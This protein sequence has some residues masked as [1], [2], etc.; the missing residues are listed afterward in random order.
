MGIHVM[1][2]F[3][4]LTIRRGLNGSETIT[5]CNTEEYSNMVYVDDLSGEGES[6]LSSRARLVI[7][8]SDRVEEIV[9]NPNEAVDAENKRYWL[10]G[11]LNTKAS[12][13][14]VFIPVNKFTESQP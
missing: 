9:L 10:A 11:C 7:T 4:I 8:G 14:F 1:E 3:L 13:E 2:L 12:G 5:Y 6:L